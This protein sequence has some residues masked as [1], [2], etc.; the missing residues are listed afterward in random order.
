MVADLVDDLYRK[1]EAD[2]T[3]V[4]SQDKRTFA[5]LH[6]GLAKS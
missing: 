4:L 3:Q 1:F 2:V 5:S 6:A